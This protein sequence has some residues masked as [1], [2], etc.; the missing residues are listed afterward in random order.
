[1]NCIYF[2]PLVASD[3][4]WLKVTEVLVVPT[5]PEL[6]VKLDTTG[7][8]VSTTMESLIGDVRLEYSVPLSQS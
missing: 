8:T 7:G 3:M 1:M 2:T 5:A 6:I 4:V